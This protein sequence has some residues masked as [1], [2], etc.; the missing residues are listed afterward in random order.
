M[1]SKELQAALSAKRVSRE[2]E[3]ARHQR[4]MVEEARQRYLIQQIADA[5]QRSRDFLDAKLMGR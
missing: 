3:V 2:K 1:T 5:E 4:E